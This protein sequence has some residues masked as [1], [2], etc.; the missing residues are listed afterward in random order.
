LERF[1]TETFLQ[2]ADLAALTNGVRLALGQF[3]GGAKIANSA[4]SFEATDVIKDPKLPQRRLILVGTSGDLTF[5]EYE[6][7]GRG[8]HEHFVLFQVSGS[9]TT[10]IK[11]CSGLL[12]R[13]LDKLRKIVGTST[14]PWK[15]TEH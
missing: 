1:R 5:V 15:S 13:S 3:A 14:C 12:P 2:T 9:R 7:G 8:L 10:L 4:E 6:H 11:A